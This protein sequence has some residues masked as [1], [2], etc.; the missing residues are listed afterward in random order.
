[1]GG[2]GPAMEVSGTLALRGGGGWVSRGCGVYSVAVT[3]VLLG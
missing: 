3:R 2:G 1:M